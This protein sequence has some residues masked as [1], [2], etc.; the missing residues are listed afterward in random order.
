MFFNNEA[1]SH[2]PKHTHTHTP[3]G[4]GVHP[5]QHPPL[6]EVEHVHHRR[7]AR[8]RDAPGEKTDRAPI[9]LRSQHVHAHASGHPGDST[10]RG[11]R[12]ET[13][14]TGKADKHDRGPKSNRDERSHGHPFG[15]PEMHVSPKSCKC[16]IEY[17]F[18]VGIRAAKQNTNFSIGCC[19]H[20]TKHATKIKTKTTDW[21]I[22][23]SIGGA[24][25][26]ASRR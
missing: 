26:H 25:S 9:L 20:L 6:V 16:D 24:R 2:T 22:H 11:E 21:R 1:T 7:V 10:G 15:I 19:T 23:A 4:R 12:D 13:P 3:D 8:V 17:I 18:V 14:E 5:G